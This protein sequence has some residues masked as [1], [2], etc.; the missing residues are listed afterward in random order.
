MRVQ[1]E[2]LQMRTDT[3]LMLASLAF[4]IASVGMSFILIISFPNIEL[5]NIFPAFIGFWMLGAINAFAA[6]DYRKLEQWIEET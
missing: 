6:A 1:N 4:I 3:L 2:V 5:A